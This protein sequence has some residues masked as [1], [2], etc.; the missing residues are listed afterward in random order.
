MDV[1]KAVRTKR[2]IRKYDQSREISESDIIKIVEAG[3]M[4]Q[5]SKNRQPVRL[6]VI[7]DKKKLEAL[8]KCTYSGDFLP[9]SSF[10]VAVVTED[11]KL[12]DIDSA[13]A[14]QNMML[15]AWDLGIASCWITN[16]WEKGLELLNVPMNGRNK[17][18]TVFP[19]G[20]PHPDVLTPKSKKMR[21][22]FH[23]VVFRESFTNP[24]YRN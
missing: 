10:G 9:F 4:G 14:V 7:R 17:L 6:I 13:R 15:V 22:E 18:I 20:Y 3:R 24:W 5:S 2:E 23:E 11:A 21:K 19:I 1:E 16:F 8:S 12:P